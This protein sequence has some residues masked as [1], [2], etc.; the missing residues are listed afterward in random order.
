MVVDVVSSGVFVMPTLS[1][2]APTSGLVV[3]STNG[4]VVSFVDSV[5]ISGN[6]EGSGFSVVS[7]PV[8]V[9]VAVSVV[10]S[11]FETNRSVVVSVTPGVVDISSFS[12]ETLAVVVS[13]TAG[14]VTASAG[15]SVLCVGVPVCSDSVAVVAAVTVDIFSLSS[16]RLLSSSGFETS[17]VASGE[18]LVV[19]P[20]ASDT[21]VVIPFVE[22]V[23]LLGVIGSSVTSV[24][25]VAGS[26]VATP[27]SV[28]AVVGSLVVFCSTSE[29]RVAG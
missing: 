17:V 13:W 19:I 1:V 24:T 16:S 3:V 11:S 23:S 28:M 15:T 12:V 4:S 7:A 9:A 5:V 14:V 8:P 22:G 6:V 27:A 21:L 10:V 29:V 20:L 25:Y 18:R 26:A 2:V